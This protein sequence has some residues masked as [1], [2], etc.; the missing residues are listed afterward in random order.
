MDTLAHAMFAGALRKTLRDS[1][2]DEVQ[3]KKLSRKEFLWSMFWGA[4]PDLFAFGIGIGI[5]LVVT[6]EFWGGIMIAG[7]SL[8]GFL[9]QFSHSLVIVLAVMGVLWF[10]KKRWI[11]II[12][13]WPLHIIFDM[14]TH[15]PNGYPTPFL[16]PLSDW[17]LPFGIQ[18]STPW[19]WIT[20]WVVVAI[21][22]IGL[23]IYDRRN[24][25]A[26]TKVK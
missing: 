3:E 17:T 9:Y 21:I 5:S 13:G 15:A 25:K 22:Y 26:S 1:K 23:A 6:G 16:F 18:W 4:F 11:W 10:T 8:S 12:L 7:K 2:K 19:F 14:P 20:T 24:R